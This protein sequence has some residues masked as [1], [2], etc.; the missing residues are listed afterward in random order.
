M[1]SPHGLGMGGRMDQLMVQVDEEVP[2]HVGWEGKV[3]WK[4][5]EV[6]R[7]WLLWSAPLCRRARPCGGGRTLVAY[8]IGRGSS[9]SR[10][11]GDFLLFF[12]AAKI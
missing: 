7:C 2:G 11:F 3:W 5:G 10:R 4:Y 9:P 1:W 12:Y 8:L 6:G